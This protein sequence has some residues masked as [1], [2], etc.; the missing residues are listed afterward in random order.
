[1]PENLKEIISFKDSYMLELGDITIECLPCQAGHSASD[2]LIYI[3][4]EEFL[5]TGD[6]AQPYIQKD[7]NMEQ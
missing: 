4:Q 3:P 6:A 2:I 7:V 1:M 5:F